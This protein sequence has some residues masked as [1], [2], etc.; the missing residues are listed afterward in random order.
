MLHINGLTH[1]DTFNKILKLTL[2]IILLLPGYLTAQ[3]LLKQFQGIGDPTAGHV[4]KTSDGGYILSGTFGI[5]GTYAGMLVMKT[6]GDFQEEW[7]Q[8][9]QSSD[10]H[11][12]YGIDAIETADGGYLVLGAYDTEIWKS[13][14]L[15]KLDYCLIKLDSQGQIVWAKRYGG[16]RTDL[17]YELSETAD[18][19]YI[20][21]GYSSQGSSGL[22]NPQPF[23]L[24]VDPSGTIIWSRLQRAFT[25][26][27]ATALLAHPS[28]QMK[29]IQTADGGT[30]YGISGG[31]L[32]WFIKMDSNGDI[33]W[34]YKAPMGGGVM[35]GDAQALWGVA[36]AGGFFSD[37]EELPNGDIAM[38]GNVFYF[39]AIGNGQNGGSIYIPVAFILRISSTGQ[40]KYAQA[41]FHP[42]GQSGNVTDL[43]GS[44]LEVLPNGNFLVGGAIGGYKAFFLE[45]DPSVSTIDNAKVWARG[46]GG[47]NPAGFPY[48]YDI[49]NITIGHD[50]NYLM[51]FDNLKLKQLSATDPLGDSCSHN[52]T[53]NSFPFTPQ[54]QAGTATIDSIMQEQAVAYQSSPRTTT[55][56]LLCAA[57]TT[58]V[59]NHIEAKTLQVFPNPA[60]DILNITIPGNQPEAMTISLMDLNGRTI[61]REQSHAQPGSNVT[62]SLL[63]LAEGMYILKVEKG[64]ELYT[65]KILVRR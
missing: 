31:E 39:I 12:D 57:Q 2:A 34:Q 56:T 46:F 1:M 13:P 17:P 23:L 43:Y 49:P 65:N 55:D 40:V 21:T 63:D 60:T 3:N 41:F 26:N 24:K 27:I 61:R 35:G 29:S 4:R 10:D 8:V 48:D 52:L 16:G 6:D 18:G 11:L 15:S 20:V 37:V 28:F 32:A 51:W 38:L 19:N 59:F 14:I 22:G 42:T 33:L 64:Q 54:F 5:G 30:F 7:S 58:S 62:I 44:D 9:L 36:A 47:L 53:I 25:F 50:G 45:I